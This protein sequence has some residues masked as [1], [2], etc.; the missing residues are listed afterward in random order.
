M[1]LKGPPRA[2]WCEPEHLLASLYGFLHLPCSQLQSTSDVGAFLDLLRRYTE[3]L[4]S[5]LPPSSTSC[6]R[7][8]QA[9]VRDWP[10]TLCGKTL[11]HC[12]PGFDCLLPAPPGSAGQPASPP[13]PNPATATG[14]TFRLQAPGTGNDGG[15]APLWPGLSKAD[16]DALTGALG[17]LS[18]SGGVDVVW[19]PEY[20]AALLALRPQAGHIQAAADE[21]SLSLVGLDDW[22]FQAHRCAGG[23]AKYRP[24]ILCW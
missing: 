3:A 23:G 21:V 16:L 6:C 9:A 2:P 24:P 12:C 19:F 7:I 11:R 22:S 18:S 5:P 17:M 4:V 8:C 15:E 10:V 13:D 20:G 1:E 14:G